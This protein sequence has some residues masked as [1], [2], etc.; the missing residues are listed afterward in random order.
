MKLIKIYIVLSIEILT[1]FTINAQSLYSAGQTIVGNG[2]TYKCDN[3]YG[4]LVLHNATDI[5]TSL[6]GGMKMKD[7][8]PFTFE[9]RENPKGFI[10]SFESF[11]DMINTIK[12]QFTAAQV[13]MVTGARPL[14]VSMYINSDTGVIQGVSFDFLDSEPWA[15]IPIDTYRAIEVALKSKFT[16][17]ITDQGKKYNYNLCWTGIIF[18]KPK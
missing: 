18:P 1:I 15:K 5:W 14:T 13:S 8:S 17:Q 7:G 10:Q 6:S 3:D 4:V 11:T 2:F 12:S 16:F 9:L